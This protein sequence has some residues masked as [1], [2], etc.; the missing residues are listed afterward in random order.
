MDYRNLELVGKFSAA[1][2]GNA[3]LRYTE[4]SVVQVSRKTAQGA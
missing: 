4:R 1:L 3:H 2:F